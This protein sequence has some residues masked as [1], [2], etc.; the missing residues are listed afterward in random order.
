MGYHVVEYRD[1]TD[2]RPVIVASPTTAVTKEKLEDEVEDLEVSFE[3]LYYGGKC[4]LEKP[5]KRW[6][7]ENFESHKKKSARDHSMRNQPQLQILRKAD[8][9]WT[10]YKFNLKRTSSI[11]GEQIGNP[12]CIEQV[13]SMVNWLEIWFVVNKSMVNRLNI[14]VNKFDSYEQIET[15]S[16]IYEWINRS[17]SSIDHHHQLWLLLSLIMIINYDKLFDTTWIHKK[18][19][20]HFNVHSN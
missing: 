5:K 16:L 13:W 7:Y 1:E 20:V 15:F 12:I 8:L 6:F 11:H 17:S 18:I 4:E 19:H 9:W 2:N 14:L 3:R 10:D